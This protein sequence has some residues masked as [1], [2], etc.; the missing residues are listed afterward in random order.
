MK[1]YKIGGVYIGFLYACSDYFTGRIEKYEDNSQEPKYMMTSMIK[2]ELTL[3]KG[4]CILEQ[5]N[6]KVFQEGNLEILCIYQNNL[7][8]ASKITYSL[9]YKRVECEFA[10]HYNK[11]LAETEYIMTG[12][13]FLEMMFQESCIAI[14]ASAIAYQNQAIL[15]SAPS[16]TGKS[17]HANLWE[18]HLDEISFINDDK[19]LIQMKDN[20]M[21][22]IGTPWSGKTVRNENLNLPI[23]AIVFIEQSK[24]DVI[25]ELSNK[26]KLIH[27]MRNSYRTHHLEKNDYVL[28]VMDQLIKHVDMFLL[29]CTPNDSAFITS[30]NRIFKEENTY[31]N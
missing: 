28:H 7:H 5:G 30:Y 21:I 17:T 16:G 12:L 15:F 8:L 25:V 20:Q 11:R 19:P 13:F 2:D 9:D 29:Q 31:E 26:E 27:L 4:K 18:K 24:T 23:K 1:T 6:R 10:S 3:P 22:V 14:H